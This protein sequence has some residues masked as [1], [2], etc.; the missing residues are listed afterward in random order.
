APELAADPPAEPRPHTDVYGLGA[1]L[2]AL[3]TGRPPLGGTTASETL[4]QVRTREPVPPSQFNSE[5]TP[6]LEAVCLKCLRKNPW[7]PDPHSYDLLKRLRYSQDNPS[8][9]DS[10][11][12]RPRRPR[13]EE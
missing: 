12:E 10:S 1:I 6:P 13:H 11:G 5:V 3:L 4:E 9:Q 8:G 2:Y 7:R